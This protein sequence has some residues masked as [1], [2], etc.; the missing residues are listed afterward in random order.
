[1]PRCKPDAYGVQPEIAALYDEIEAICHDGGELHHIWTT[2][3]PAIALHPCRPKSIDDREV[4]MRIL[5]ALGLET[6]RQKQR[7]LLVARYERNQR[8]N[9]A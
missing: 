2:I 3:A 8:R 4:T 7:R 1:M 9:E 6:T 5:A